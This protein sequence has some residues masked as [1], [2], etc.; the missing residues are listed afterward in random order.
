MPN[1]FDPTQLLEGDVLEERGLVLDTS[2]EGQ[3]IGLSSGHIFGIYVSD[4]PAMTAVEDWSI[5]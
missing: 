4:P 2:L 3:A 5:W 1:E